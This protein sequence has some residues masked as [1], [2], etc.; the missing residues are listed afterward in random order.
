MNVKQLKMLAA[1]FAAL[2]LVIFA[3]SALAQNQDEMKASK[4]AEIVLTKAAQVGGVVLP[5]GRYTFRHEVSQGQHFAT[6]VGPEGTKSTT[7]KEIK[8]TNEPLKQAVKQTS[9][10]VENVGGVDKITRIEVKGE[11]VAHIF[12]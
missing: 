5:A 10:S 1:I 8:C 9:V 11:N 6:F 4:K 12:S 3:G 2:I 7:I